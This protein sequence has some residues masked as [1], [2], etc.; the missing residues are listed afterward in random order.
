[1]E[2]FIQVNLPPTEQDY[3]SGSGEGCWFIV[4]DETKAAYDRNE[5]STGKLYEGT[6]DNDSIYYPT[7]NHGER[8]P[9]EMR[10]DKR[11]VVPYSYLL[12]HYGKPD[13][14]SY[15]M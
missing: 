11:P 10:G 13:E 5:Q 14:S 8:L 6:L 9:I 12:Q 1:M 15:R 2:N 3:L 7:L 4:D